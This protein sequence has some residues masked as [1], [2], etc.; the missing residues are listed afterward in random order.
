MKIGLVAMS[1]IRVVDPELMRLGLTLPG[2]VERGRVIAS[3]PSLGLLTLAGMTPSKHQCEYHEVRDL[4][5]METLPADLDL[6]AISSLSAQVGEAYT[7]ADRFRDAGVPV[8]MGGLH[9]S[10]LPDEAAQHA[11]VVIVGEGESVWLDVLRDAEAGTLKPC[12]SANDRFSLDDSPLPAF[13]L[14]DIEKYNR[15]TV[16]AS[17]GCPFRCEFCASSILLTRRYKQKPI[18]RVLAEIDHIRAVWKRPFIEFADDNAFVNRRYWKAL[19]PELKK[20]KV[21]WFAETDLSVH[22][23]DELLGLMRASGCAE[24]LIGFESPG[25]SGLRGIE[26]KRDWKQKHWQEAKQAVDR[27]QSHGIRVNGCFILGL[28]G[29][30]PDIFADVLEFAMET[31]LFDVQI[32]V[33]TPFPGTPLYARLKREGRLIRDEAWETCTLFDV[34]FRPQL[35][36]AEELRNGFR[37]LGVQ[38]YSHELTERRRAGFD[39]K[40]REAAQRWEES[41]P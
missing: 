10:A 34:N 30:G 15:L 40:F 1:G 37:D 22:E 35:M 9:V 7:L 11:D 41:H 24:V 19:L 14:L 39:R 17:R 31:E 33:Q 20:R 3:L 16:Q 27:I 13:E 21:R 23:D 12:Y 4:H 28:D 5:V 6:V 29:Q 32:T 36:T 2:F 18:D 38:L 8:V 26:L 25:A